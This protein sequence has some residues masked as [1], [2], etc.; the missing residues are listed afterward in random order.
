MLLAL[1]YFETLKL[2]R[3]TGLIALILSVIV[4]WKI[5]RILLLA[6]LAV[7]LAT[8]LNQGVRRLQRVVLHRNLAVF[9]LLAMLLAL[10]TIFGIAI[11]PPFVE[12][13]QD[14]IAL[15]PAVISRIQIQT[16]WLQRVLPDMLLESLENSLLG[17]QPV[18]QTWGRN[19]FGNFLTFFS[20]ALGI[21][22]NILL[23]IVLIVMVLANPSQYRRAFLLL[24]PTPFRFRLDQVLDHCET[25]IG[26]WFI[27]I[28]FNMTVITVL[29]GV[30]L[31]ILG[32]PLVLAN[33]LLAGLLA[34]VPNVGPVLSVIPPAA[35]ALLDA[36]WKAL[37]V[38][39]LYIVVQQVESNILTPI[40]MQKQ[41]DLLP[42][43]TLVAQISF[44]VLFGF[45]GL[46]LA[47]PLTIIVQIF[48]QEFWIKD[49]ALPKQI[50]G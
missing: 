4:V 50:E 26:G 24:F 31:W 5:R 37:A 13:V 32:V 23:V 36:P 39:G 46:F 10:F 44:A 49:W 3:W 6:F 42:A 27:G 40:V 12:Q 35:V 11:V 1:R 29:S 38:V 8:V 18:I 47:L 30:G 7:V 28:L 25:S 14:L 9:C 48:L 41:V 20:N 43:V 22:L 45:L 33:A 15:L 17:L 16:D 19:I 2:D 21:M 34:F